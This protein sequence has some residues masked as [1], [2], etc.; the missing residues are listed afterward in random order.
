MG[1]GALST[2]ASELVSH[3][4]DDEAVAAMDRILPEPID[5]EHVLA[6]GADGSLWAWGDDS[7]GELGPAGGAGLLPVKVP[8]SGVVRATAGNGF[9]VAQVVLGYGD[10]SQVIN[11]LV[12]SGKI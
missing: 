3:G 1:R 2:P 12:A 11:E 10:V 7:C 4:S 8:L 6:V 5:A 9:S